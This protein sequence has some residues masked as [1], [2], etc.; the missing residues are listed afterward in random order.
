MIVNIKGKDI[1]LKYTI[2]ALMMY[3]NMMENTFNPQGVTDMVTFFYCIVLASSKDY[4]ITFD[5]FIDYIDNSNYVLNDFK[6]W[7]SKVIENN[8]IIKKN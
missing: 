6:E 8:N 2:R 7:I 4:S 5:E 3:E 1:E